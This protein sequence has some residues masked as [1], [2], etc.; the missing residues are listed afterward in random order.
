[1][2][3]IVL[4]IVEGWRHRRALRLLLQDSSSGQRLLD[5][6]PEVCVQ[7]GIKALALDFDGVL[8][9]H[10]A[11]C[12]LPETEAWLQCAV[13]VCGEERIVILSNRPEEGRIAWFKERFPGVR[14]IAGVRKK[15]YPDGLEKTGELLGVPLSTIL[16]VDDRLLTGCLAAICAGSVPYYIRSPYRDF[17]RETVHELVFAGLRKLERLLVR[18]LP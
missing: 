3:H 5:L 9:P 10:G 11:A 14:F 2:H 8:A 1:M 4:G 12:P 7:N 6:Q 15:P 18:L 13:A 17:R 16:M